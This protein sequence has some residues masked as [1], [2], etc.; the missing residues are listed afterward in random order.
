MPMQTNQGETVKLDEA[1]AKAIEEAKLR[2]LNVETEV[3]IAS[4]NLKVIK[5]DIEKATNEKKYQEDLL[6]K[7][8]S[9]LDEANIRLSS[10]MASALTGSNALSEINQEISKKSDILKAMEIEFRKREDAISS[11]ESELISRESSV[12]LREEDVS[13]S[14][15]QLQDKHAKIKAFAETI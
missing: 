1:Q 15:E 9:Q 12:E 5:A 10:L 4:K 14:E 2:L 7:V 3:S 8:T 6:G 11:K 13:K